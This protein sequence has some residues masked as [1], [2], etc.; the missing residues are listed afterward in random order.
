MNAYVACDMCICICVCEVHHQEHVGVHLSPHPHLLQ[1]LN[2]QLN[3]SYVVIVVEDVYEYLIIQIYIIP[4]NI[5]I[6]YNITYQCGV[7]IKNARGVNARG[8][9]APSKPQPRGELNLLEGRH[10]VFCV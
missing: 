5:R 10:E 8:F 7:R 6:V 9:N 4:D 1:H 2:P 3:M